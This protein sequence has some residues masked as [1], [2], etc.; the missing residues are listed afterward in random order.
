MVT[1]GL[2]SSAGSG[3]WSSS[4][5]SDRASRTVARSR[6]RA[7]RGSLA[8]WRLLGERGQAQRGNEA[9]YSQRLRAAVI[10][11]CSMSCWLISSVTPTPGMVRCS[12]SRGPGQAPGGQD[13]PGMRGT[14]PYRF[15]WPL[16]GYAPGV[17]AVPNSPARPPPLIIAP[18]DRVGRPPCGLIRCWSGQHPLNDA[19]L[20]RGLDHCRS[21][22][23]AGQPR[24]VVKA[25][26]PEDAAQRAHG[27]CE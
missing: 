23:V 9:S 7:P 13:G 1:C 4:Q 3:T 14:R 25:E 18:C 6:R 5:V 10:T 17:E 15:S 21:V 26:P 19:E 8:G 22:G 24:R 2:K 11:M 16:E 20:L 27:I 12:P